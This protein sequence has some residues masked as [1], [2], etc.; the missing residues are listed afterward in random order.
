MGSAVGA[1]ASVEDADVVNPVEDR[2]SVAG[3]RAR[4]QAYGTRTGYAVGV[5]HPD[6]DMGWVHPDDVLDPNA[7]PGV[8]RGDVCA[9][10]LLV[11]P[12]V[13]RAERS[14]AEDGVCHHATTS[15]R[16]KDA[17]WLCR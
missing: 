11:R 5:L 14:Y 3:D 16:G 10:L 4:H 7:D 6:K 8:G 9:V 2:L 12:L 13:E 1:R 17:P 15:G